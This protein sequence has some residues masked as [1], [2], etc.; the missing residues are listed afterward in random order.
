MVRRLSWIGEGGLAGYSEEGRL[1][2][3]G[4]VSWIWGEKGYLGTRRR[5]DR[6]RGAA[7]WIW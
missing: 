7:G 1:D 3:I 5:A 2:T 4:R 6:I